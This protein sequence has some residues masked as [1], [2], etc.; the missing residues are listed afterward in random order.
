MYDQLIET[1]NEISYLGITR[2]STGGWNRHRMKQM[3][4][5]NQSLVAIDKCL[6]R[7][8]E[9]RIQ[10]LENVYE[11]V[12]ESRMIYGA[13]IRG[14]DEEW[15]ETDI[16][17]GRLCKKILGIPRFAANGVAEIQLARDSRRGKVLCLAVKYWLRTLQMDKE[18]LV[19]VCYEWQV[20]NFDFDSWA[21]KLNEQ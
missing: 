4:K 14:L 21:S 17:H 3:V 18:E 19:R 7:T 6:T 12:C 9:M 20:N 8:P 2:E 13:E 10:L 11:L 5:G 1:V 16:I 15:K